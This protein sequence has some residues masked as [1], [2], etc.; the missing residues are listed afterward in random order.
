MGG[1]ADQ[2]TWHSDAG[3]WRTEADVSRD[4]ITLGP[5]IRSSLLREEH[6]SKDLAPDPKIRNKKSGPSGPAKRDI[7]F[8]HAARLGCHWEL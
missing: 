4:A 3:K 2:G 7:L 5:W 6:E 8:K 1:T